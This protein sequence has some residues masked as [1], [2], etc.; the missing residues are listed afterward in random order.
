ML[1][2]RLLRDVAEAMFGAD[3]KGRLI[4]HAPRLH[5]LRTRDGVICRCHADLP[6]GVADEVGRLALAPR[7][8][9]RDW[10]RDHASYVRLVSAG[11][12]LKAVRAGLLYC[13]PDPIAGGDEAVGI[14]QANA[15]LLMQGLDEWRPDVGAGRPMAAMVVNGRSVSVCASVIASVT[16]H[17]AGVE[18]LPQFRG[19]G[20][21]RKAVASWARAV[22]AGG[23]TPVYGT[24]FDNLA[25]QG[26]ASRLNLS[27]VGSEF[28]IE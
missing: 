10:S 8:R 1:N 5:I 2:S 20:L 23:A 9:P 22:Q 24:T 4:G 3:E 28:S 12:P 25:S 7:G 11:G 26:L 21:G 17:C 13:F 27:L 15:D 14:D 16:V 6:D 18:T 19:R